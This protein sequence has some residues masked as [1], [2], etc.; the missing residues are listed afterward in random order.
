MYLKY[1]RDYLKDFLD[2]CD[3]NKQNLKILNTVLNLLKETIILGLWDEIEDFRRLIPS[4]VRRIL[5]IDSI[6]NSKESLRLNKPEKALLID[7]K[8]KTTQ[9]FKY[10]S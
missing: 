1:I 8:I 4:L 5:K 6:N 9:I 10:I 3:Q 7:C 2:N